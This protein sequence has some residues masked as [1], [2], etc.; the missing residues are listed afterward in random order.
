MGTEVEVALALKK[1][2]PVTLKGIVIYHHRNICG[3][4]FRV[5]PGMAVQFRDI[6]AED[7][8]LL[9]DYITELFARDIIE[10]QDEPVIA[11]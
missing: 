5:A 10:E 11:V 8:K 3:D 2:R 1:E 6:S 7:S 4:E 9:R